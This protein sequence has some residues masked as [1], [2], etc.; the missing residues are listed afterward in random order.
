MQEYLTVNQALSL[1]FLVYFTQNLWCCW[2]GFRKVRQTLPSR[3]VTFMLVC[4]MSTIPWLVPY[5]IGRDQK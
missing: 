1:G 2:I 3:T 4:L 5:L